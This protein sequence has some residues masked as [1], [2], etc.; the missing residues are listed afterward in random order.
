MD[1]KRLHDIISEEITRFIL[2]EGGPGSGVSKKNTRSINTFLTKHEHPT[3][4]LGPITVGKR[5]KFMDER[6]PKKMN[7]PLSK[8][9]HVGQ[10]TYVPTK[11]SG[12]MKNNEVDNLPVQLL[13]MKNGNFQVIDG[14]HRFLKFIS[15]NKGQIKAEVYEE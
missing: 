14:H 4:S 9:T 11:L 3:C 7:V 6:K 13:K 1:S 15:N 2:K 8:I 12:M 5:G 10:E